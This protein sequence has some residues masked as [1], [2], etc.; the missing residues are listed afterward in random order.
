VHVLNLKPTHPPA[1]FKK[2]RKNSVFGRFSARGVQKHHKTVF[3]KSPCRKRFPKKSTKIS[4]SVFPR[5]FL[6]YRGFGCSQRWEF[7]NTTKAFK[8]KSCP[9]VFTKN[10]TNNPNDFFLDFVYHVFGRFSARGVQKHDQKNIEKMNLT[11]VLFWPLTHPPTTAVTDFVWRP[12]EHQHQRTAHS[13]LSTQHCTQH[14]TLCLC[15]LLVAG[16]CQ[17]P[18]VQGSLAKGQGPRAKGR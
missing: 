13:A 11:L 9:K 17:L 7:K 16:C 12:L 14:S 4:M 15:Q 3:T 10:S 1:G 5:L 6:F 8:K 18:L 2:E